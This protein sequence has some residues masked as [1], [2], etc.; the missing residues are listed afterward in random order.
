MKTSGEIPSR[1]AS[2]RRRSEEAASIPRVTP[3]TTVAPRKNSYAVEENVNEEPFDYFKKSPKA[4]SLNEAVT[5]SSRRSSVSA[6]Q[7]R[8]DSPK[9]EI[10]ESTENLVSNSI[11]PEGPIP[12]NI[13]ST[14]LLEEQPLDT[15]VKSNTLD[16]PS[17]TSPEE[18]NDFTKTVAQLS[19]TAKPDESYVPQNG[20]SR[21]NTIRSRGN[22]NVAE[23]PFTA[24]IAEGSKSRGRTRAPKKLDQQ[25]IPNAVPVRNVER[26][27]RRRGTN[28]NAV[29]QATNAEKVQPDFQFKPARK[30]DSPVVQ[31]SSL[32]QSSPKIREVRRRPAVSTAS[33]GIIEQQGRRINGRTKTGNPPPSQIFPSR[34]ANAARSREL[35]QII[36]EQKLEV[37]PLFESEPK[38]VRPSTRSRVKE[39]TLRTVEGTTKPTKKVVRSRGKARNSVSA[40]DVFLT[41]ATETD[42]K[43]TKPNDSPSV[44]SVSV[45]VETRTESSSS[46]KRRPVNKKPQI[47]E[48]VVSQITEITSKQ[49][50]PRRKNSNQNLISARSKVDS[51][52]NR[53]KE[54]I[55]ASRGNKKSEIRLNEIK[56]SKGDGSDEIDES[57]NYPEPFKAL[58][59]AKKSQVCYI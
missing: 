44:I 31:R 42:L 18:F 55:I 9:P 47:K 52:K 37:L 10:P 6:P 15:T 22:N 26:P 41:S 29:P 1:R 45:N 54:K 27:S 33:R 39:R 43:F 5:P 56:R 2:S 14:E 25:F 24:Q 46:F 17:E 57:D 8:T 35:P 20:G 12:Q 13:P 50:I 7:S 30:T 4:K 3:R 40:E 21:R 11:I 51:Q 19:T 34:N 16:I 53:I 32:D 49:T 38:T 58:I 23:K 36:D 59:N 48:S 28:S